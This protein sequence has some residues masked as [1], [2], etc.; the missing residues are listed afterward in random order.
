MFD[1]NKDLGETISGEFVRGIPVFSQRRI[2]QFA[3]PVVDRMG[4]T[5]PPEQKTIDDTTIETQAVA[6]NLLGEAG[7]AVVLRMAQT[8]SADRFLLIDSERRVV[9]LV[10]RDARLQPAGYSGYARGVRQPGDLKAA[11]LQ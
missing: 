5:L 1:R 7:T 2:A 4:T 3:D 11:P 8:S 6:D 10:V 9:G